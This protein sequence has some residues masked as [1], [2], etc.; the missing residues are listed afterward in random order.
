M[1]HAIRA[2]SEHGYALLF[3]LVFLDQVL[4]SIPSPPFLVAAG[5]M[6]R[7]I[8]HIFAPLGI[9]IAAGMLADTCWFAFGMYG[10]PARVQRFL[11]RRKHRRVGWTMTLFEKN[12]GGTLLAV[13]F[14][15]I[16]TAFV[17]LLAGAR[18][19]SAPSF[20]TF[21]AMSNAVFGAAFL[22]T[23]FFLKSVV[24]TPGVV[25]HS[26]TRYGIWA[27]CAIFAGMLTW[28]LVRRFFN[29]IG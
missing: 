6:L 4:I 24:L 29:K 18:K 5:V 26:L 1:L 19:I 16:P 7:G 11:E 2:L 3:L 20:F 23:G 10:G 8:E 13:K 22:L 27:A 25:E 28:R 21:D 9:A 15:P 12:L 17:P 14:L